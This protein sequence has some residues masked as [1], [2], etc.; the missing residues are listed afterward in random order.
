MK[1]KR[2]NKA[3]IIGAGA[4][5]SAMAVVL[6]D[7]GYDV[8]LWARSEATVRCFEANRGVPRLP[9]TALPENIAVTTDVDQA[10]SGASLV[11]S[12]IPSSALGQ[13]A[14]EIAGRLPDDALV[15]TATKG[16]DLET[17]RRPSQVWIDANPSLKHRMCV[18]SGPNFAAEIAQRLPAA[19]V[20]AASEES[21]RLAVQHAFMTKYFRVYTHVDVTG[22]EIGGALKNVIALACG[23]AQGM[24]AGYN[25]QAAIISRGIAEISR[26]GVA[27]GAQPL[28]F[29]G[30][31][32]L[33]DLVLT[34]T[35]HLSR[36]RQAGIA[37]GQGESIH[38]FL[39]RT[40]YTVEG[41]E[42]VKAATQL[43]STCDVQMPITD[44][45]YRILYEGLP[46]HKGLYEAMSRER[47]PEVEEHLLKFL[48]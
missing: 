19:T 21:T 1:G 4:W 46:P 33:G 41:L 40:G 28:T 13:V 30:L 36:N 25:I 18:I 17:L 45:V 16:F 48:A 47:K 22:V 39:A 26:L 15:V 34:C 20:V 35:G 42:T 11:V 12:A 31:S 3:C 24:G 9:G 14:R 23:M 10:L 7:N 32:G 5:G 44:V 8:T 37:V 43:S 6:S 29:S 2:G 38:G 27:L